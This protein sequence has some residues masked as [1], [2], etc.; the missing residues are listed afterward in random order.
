MNITMKAVKLKSIDQFDSR[1]GQNGKM[2]FQGA[3]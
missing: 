1:R 2:Q 3:L